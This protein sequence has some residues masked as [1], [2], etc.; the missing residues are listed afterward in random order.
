MA[1]SVLLDRTA[2]A[3]HDHERRQYGSQM[4]ASQFQNINRHRNYGPDGLTR[5]NL[6]DRI[7]DEL[8][9]SIVRGHPLPGSALPNETVLSKKFN[10]SRTALREAVRA[11]AA[12]GMV[13]SRP[14]TGTRVCARANWN[15]L[16]P[17]ILTWLVNAGPI[18][19][20]ADKLYEMRQIIEPAAASLFAA[21][22][23]ADGVRALETAYEDMETAGDIIEDG[24]EP[25]LRFHVTILMAS[26][27]P[28]LASFGS[29]IEVALTSAF[30]I[31]K[32]FPGAPLGFL[33]HHRTVLEAIRDGDPAAAHAAMSELIRDAHSDFNKGMNYLKHK[34]GGS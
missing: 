23:T 27:N 12:K 10:V 24:H 21:R 11:L 26:G 20:V 19:D 34:K 16:D 31:S 9:M 30:R 22:V 13:T 14:R 8:G 5:R 29:L 25:D 3:G 18:E 15:M 7:A 32:S 6:H 2:T 33:P 4:P 1:K 28:F 17:D